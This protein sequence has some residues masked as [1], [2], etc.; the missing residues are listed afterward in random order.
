MTTDRAYRLGYDCGYN[1][2]TLT[3]CSFSIFSTSE[4]TKEWERGKK[5]GEESKKAKQ[6]LDKKLIKDRGQQ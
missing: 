3:N 2:S 5:E 1:G 4:N 6:Q